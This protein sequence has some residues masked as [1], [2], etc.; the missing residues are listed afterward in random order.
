[1]ALRESTIVLF[2]IDGTLTLP[3]KNVEPETKA[4]LAQLR[5]AATIGIVGGS[6]HVKQHE[7]LGSSVLEDFDYVFAEN[8]LVAFKEGKLLATQSLRDFYGDEKLK[9]FINFCLHY[10]ADLD[11]PVKRGTFIEFR[12]GMLNVSPIGRNCNQKERDDFEAYDK[13]HGIRQAMVAVLKEKF[14]DMKLTF[15]IGGQISFD[16]FPV[17]W[18]KTYCLRYLDTFKTVHFFGDKTAPGGNDHE[19]FASERTVGHTVTNPSDTI[20]QCTALFLS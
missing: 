3:R 17:G 10:I 16:V 6:D 4:F 12:N 18:D 8:G 14:E 5:K 20:A 9:R 2:D 1:M 13:I 19:I 11:I 15:S 7:Q